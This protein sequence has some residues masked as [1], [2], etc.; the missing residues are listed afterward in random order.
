MAVERQAHLD[1]QLAARDRALAQQAADRLR[2]L[3]EELASGEVESVLALTPDQRLRFDEWSTRRL[4]ELAERFDVD[5]TVSQKRV[6]WGMRIASTLGGI[7]VCAAVVLFFMRYWGY[8][9][10]WLQL[11]IVILTPLLSLCGAER[12]ARRERTRYFTGL[13]ALVT[14]A[15]FILNLVVV[16]TIFNI[17]S[18]ENSML[19]WGAL[20]LV[21]AYRY[22]LRLIL[23]LGLLFLIGYV[24]A[25]FTARMGYRWLE[26]WDRPEQFLL[27]GLLVFAIPLLLKPARQANFAPVFRLVGALTFFLAVLS[28]ADWGAPSYLNWDA[29][30]VERLYEFFGLIASAGAIWLGIARNWN[31]LVNTGSVFFTLFLVTRLYHWWWAWMPKYLFFAAIGALGIGLVLVFKRLRAS[32]IPANSAVTA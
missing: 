19:A 17:V 15:S 4:A 30:N 32:M 3:R 22:G 27:L 20:A 21:L 13:L 1:A 31:G 6:S 8:L 26:F 16:G 11:L 29:R 5:T 10:T 9:D 25:A 23:A 24:A 2:M 14:I 28:L 12:M 7:A 18:T